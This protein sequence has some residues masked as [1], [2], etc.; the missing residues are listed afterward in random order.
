M[1]IEQR[2]LSPGG[3]W[4]SRPASAAN[5]RPPQLVLAFGPRES[6]GDGVFFDRLQS[7]YPNSHLLIASGSGS[8]AG[9]EIVDDQFVVTALTFD[10][11]SVIVAS[12]EIAHREDSF[13][14]GE[15][16]ATQLGAPDLVHVFVFADGQLTSGSQL[17]QGLNRHLPIGVSV[18]GGLA[19]DGVR[20]QSTLIGLD[21]SPASGRVVAI[22]LAGS[23]LRVGSGCGRGWVPFGLERLVTRSDGPVLHELDGQSSLGLYKNYLGA[24][25]ASLPLSALR[26]PLLMIPQDGSPAVVRTPHAVNESDGSMSFAGD[27]PPQARVRFLRASYQNLVDGAGEAATQSIAAGEPELVLCVSCVARRVI[28]GQ[29]TEEELETVRDV[30]GPAPVIAGFYSYGELAPSEKQSDCQF[31]NQTMTITTLREL[32]A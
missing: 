2:V 10:Q 28:L 7:A 8:I 1:K 6:L 31:H 5:E 16:L 14:A 15:R 9:P 30:I 11:S 19:G 4:P 21:Q 25:S 29:R 13:S 3:Q 22:G 24:E 27:I 17:A 18:S 32:P 26:F 23:R 20:F 12:T